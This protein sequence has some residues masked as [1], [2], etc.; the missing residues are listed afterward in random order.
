M[1]SEYV[2]Y[3]GSARIGLLQL[4]MFPRELLARSQETIA[5]IVAKHVDIQDIKGV[6]KSVYAIDTVQRIYIQLT[7]MAHY[8]RTKITQDIL[9]LYA[10]PLA[11]KSDVEKFRTDLYELGFLKNILDRVVTDPNI[12]GE[13]AELQALEAITGS[14]QGTTTL[15]QVEL[16]ACHD[17]LIDARKKHEDGRPMPT[18]MGILDQL[19]A[20]QRDRLRSL[21]MLDHC[22]TS[23]SCNACTRTI[24][25][26]SDEPCRD[27]RAPDQRSR[28]RGTLNPRP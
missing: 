13:K 11:N 15:S 25:Y 16:S 4:L 26:T 14:F 9:S 8:D 6:N 19:S 3:T 28:T 27:V 18:L 17:I 5:R 23:P 1:Y 21:W 2:D 20:S 7:N 24:S 10:R 12:I 22:R